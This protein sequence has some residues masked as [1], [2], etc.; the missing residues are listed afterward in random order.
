MNASKNITLPALIAILSLA[1]LGS[2]QAGDG[3]QTIKPLQGV[4]FHIGTK[5]AV[6]YFLSDNNTCKLVV[7]A[8]D[9]ANFA[10]TRSEAAIQPGKST[11]YELSEGTSLEFACQAG[12]LAMN[13]RSLEAVAGETPNALPVENLIQAGLGG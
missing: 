10:P 4:S 7:M 3:A 6:A 8:A 11:Q 2:A 9:D 1:Y 12:G 5:H 13:V